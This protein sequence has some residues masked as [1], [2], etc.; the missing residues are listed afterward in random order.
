MKRK[1]VLRF[2]ATVV[3]QPFIYTLAKQYNVVANILKANIN[4]HKEGSMV[5][6]LT[7]TEEEFK[8]ALE[9]LQARGV[10]VSPL[11]QQI[12]WLEER[13]TQCGA[14]TVIC[15]TNALWIQRP[16]MTVSFCSEKCVVCE[17]CLKACPARAVDALYLA[18]E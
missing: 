18:G 11:E 16:A 5:V 13:C 17:R 8:T 12:V 6:E 2:P 14:C 10:Q 7:A 4:R 15:P 9:F 3:E 1:L